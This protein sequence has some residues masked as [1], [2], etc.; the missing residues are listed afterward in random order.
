MTPVLQMLK[1]QKVLVF[2]IEP[3][4]RLNSK[5]KKLI[6][7]PLPHISPPILLSIFSHSPSLSF[8]VLYRGLFLDFFLRL[9][10]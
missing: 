9:L 2:Y 6:I 5:L 4:L 3:H 10:Y 7:F 1:F 8:S